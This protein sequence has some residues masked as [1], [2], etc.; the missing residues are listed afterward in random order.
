MRTV[1]LHGHI[2]KNAGTTFDWSLQ[3]NFGKNFLDHRKDLLMRAEGCAHIEELLTNEQ[4]LCAVSSHH[5][6]RDLP[7]MPG[8]R[9]IQTYLLRHPIERIRS[10]YDF[11]RKQRGR[12]P[13]AKAAKSMSFK[14]YVEWRMLPDVAH[15]I[16]N[17]QTL[18][19]AGIHG[20]ASERDIALRYFP[21][22]LETVRSDSLI[23]LVD[24]YDESMV[25]LEDNLKECFADIDLAY[26]AQNVSKSKRGRTTRQ[27]AVANTLE[28]LGDLQC[29]VI[30]KNSF[31]LALYQLVSERL[32][33]RIR[34]IAR[35]DEKLEDFQE[36]CQRLTRRK[37]L[38]R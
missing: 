20:L 4:E 25:V 21:V 31:D 19:L 35:F 3:K 8:V 13:G 17:Y 24:R 34:D 2:F 16:R 22:A 38:G 15:T 27:D 9:F 5:M 36:R 30:D 28:E 12:T 7:D 23:G 18:Y 6:T 1:I 29:T 33:S 11:E 26:V 10:V 37:I 32:D 14:D